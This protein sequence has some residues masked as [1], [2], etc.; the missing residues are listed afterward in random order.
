MSV[1]NSDILKDEAFTALGA[2]G[3][4]RPD[5]YSIQIILGARAESIS[6]AIKQVL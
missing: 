1:K 5:R 2:K 4:I 6:E 3:V